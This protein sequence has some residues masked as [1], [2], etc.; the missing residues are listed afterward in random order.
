M[1]YHSLSRATNP[2]SL[3]FC[4]FLLAVP[5][6]CVIAS[7]NNSVEA[8]PSAIKVMSMSLRT[9]ALFASLVLIKIEEKL[10][11]AIANAIVTFIMIAFSLSLVSESIARVKAGIKIA[12]P[13]AIESQRAEGNLVLFKSR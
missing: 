12:E 5:F 11:S 13:Q 10:I 7:Q 9:N 1:H 8:F 2:S 3:I 4:A 6:N